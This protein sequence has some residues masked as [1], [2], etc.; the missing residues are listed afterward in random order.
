VD[1]LVP[2]IHSIFVD[3]PVERVETVDIH[4]DLFRVICY[5]ANREITPLILDPNDPAL[6]IH[7]D[8]CPDCGV[9]HNISY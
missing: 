2:G 7:F 9:F 3:D 4:N 8:N 1:Q 6:A 5:R